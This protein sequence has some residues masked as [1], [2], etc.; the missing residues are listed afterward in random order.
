ME[1]DDGILQLDSVGATDRAKLMAYLDYGVTDQYMYSF[2]TWY[3]QVKTLLS[4]S[5]SA[6]PDVRQMYD[7]VY[8]FVKGR[9]VH[10]TATSY[11]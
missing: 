2:V 5:R 8:Q 6:N 11:P 9:Y 1:L 4:A 10:S 7:L 3:Q